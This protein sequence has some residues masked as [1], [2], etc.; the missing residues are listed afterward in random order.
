M[1]MTITMRKKYYPI[2]EAITSTKMQRIW[3]M[4]T[5]IWL[6]GKGRR[7]EESNCFTHRSF[8]LPF[9]CWSLSP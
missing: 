4:P 2:L 3:E 8:N 9:D 5:K 1:S 7:K 6:L